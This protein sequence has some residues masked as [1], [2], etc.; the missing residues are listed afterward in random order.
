M[1]LLKSRIYTHK[2]V[3]GEVDERV[4]INILKELFQDGSIKDIQINE[5]GIKFIGTH[6]KNYIYTFEELL[7]N[8]WKP[9]I[10]KIQND[11]AL[12]IRTYQSDNEVI[13]SVPYTDIIL[14]NEEM[15]NN[16]KTK[17]TDISKHLSTTTNSDNFTTFLTFFVLKNN[18]NNNEV[19]EDILNTDVEEL[20]SLIKNS[21]FYKLINLRE[22]DIE[23][24]VKLY[25]YTVVKLSINKITHSSSDVDLINHT[26][27]ISYF[28]S[29][30]D[31][32][33]N[34]RIKLIQNR[35]G[36]KQKAHTIYLENVN[37][38]H[39]ILKQISNLIDWE[40]LMNSPVSDFKKSYLTI[41]QDV[42]NLY[43]KFKYSNV[44]NYVKELNK[45][46]TNLPKEILEYNVYLDEIIVNLDKQELFV[47]PKK[48]KHSPHTQF[49]K[50]YYESDNDLYVLEYKYDK[51]TLY[52]KYSSLNNL[53][54]HIKFIYSLTTIN[55]TVLLEMVSTYHKTMS[56]FIEI[57]NLT[58]YKVEENV[59]KNI[60]F[61]DSSLT[62]NDK[63]S[64]EYSNESRTLFNLVIDF[65]NGG[66]PIKESIMINNYHQI[67]D[68]ISE[69]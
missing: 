33:N 3:N 20:V 29:V 36:F 39:E 47:T 32:N 34:V 61:G 38:T 13:Y 44:L 52:F 19:V 63:V 18:K 4:Y 60:P 56:K 2:Y 10:L 42:Q 25:N 31:D 16:F 49:F 51:D 69:I 54:N 50:I 9:I 35:L 24:N 64:I 41:H 5:N 15:Y 43:E 53:F 45:V 17:I 8:D 40:T 1:R 58:K 46:I 7:D 68:L 59:F 28:I 37:E 21:L 55:G 14:E 23:V 67:F 57:G 48:L 30:Y 26:P 66:K 12:A 22:D 62:L 6:D 27:S 11:F 65:K